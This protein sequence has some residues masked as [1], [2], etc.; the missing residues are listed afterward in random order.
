[1]SPF[2]RDLRA[3]WS[4]PSRVTRLCIFIGTI[5][6]GYVGWYLGELCG[7]DFAGAFLVSGIGSIAGIFAGWKVAQKF[8]E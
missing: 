5:I 4:Q 6:G 2:K 7:F 3:G 8:E 1:M